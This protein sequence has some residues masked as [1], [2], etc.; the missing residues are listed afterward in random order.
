MELFDS[1]IAWNHVTREVVAMKF[2]DYFNKV[3]T[4]FIGYDDVYPSVVCFYRYRTM[5]NGLHK[6][7]TQLLGLFCN[8]VVHRK[9]PVEAVHNAMM[10]IKEYSELA[11][12]D[13]SDLEIEIERHKQTSRFSGSPRRQSARKP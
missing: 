1:V 13:V 11:L 3:D 8:L 5:P 12:H 6:A 7:K 4:D 2:D 9:F 10:Q